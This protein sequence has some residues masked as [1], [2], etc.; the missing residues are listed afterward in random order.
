MK[1]DEALDK[2]FIIDPFFYLSTSHILATC[3]ELAI[4]DREMHL[5]VIF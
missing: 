2:I 5:A 3:N 1:R 4:F